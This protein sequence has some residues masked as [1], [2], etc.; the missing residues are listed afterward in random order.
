MC[1]YTAHAFLTSS[2]PHLFPPPRPR[3][4]FTHRGHL[5][6]TGRRRHQVAPSP[7]L[8]YD[9]D[10]Q[11][12]R[13]FSTLNVH[14]SRQD[15]LLLLPLPKDIFSFSLPLDPS[16]SAIRALRVA[17]NVTISLE[18]E[19]E[20]NLHTWSGPALLAPTTTGDRLQF[21]RSA[22]SR[23]S[24]KHVPFLSCQ[25]SLPQENTVYVA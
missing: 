19:E 16:H 14:P 21:R 9:S 25:P 10:R 8:G 4:L 23:V 7:S 22:F 1:V 13:F 20:E 15:L 2:A 24:H 5:S 11:L 3:L 17:I 12:R 6:H 18:E